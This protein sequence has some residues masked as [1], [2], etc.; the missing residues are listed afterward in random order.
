MRGVFFLV[1]MIS[2]LDAI[3]ADYQLFEQN[4]KVG[5]KDHEGKVVINAAFESLGWSDGSFSVIGQVTGYKLGT[6]WGLIN[7][8]GEQITNPDFLNLIP[9]GGDRIIAR[10]EISAIATKLGCIDLRGNA[11]V[12]FK[13]DG[14]KI[15]GLQAIVFNKVE[16]TFQYGVVNLN[17]TVIIPL[18]FKNIV[19]IGSLRYSVY[20]ENNKA[21]LFSEAG[22]KLT[23]FTIDSIS[24]FRN[25]NAIIYQGLTQ[26]IINREGIIKVAPLYR[27][28]VLGEKPNETRARAFD[29]WLLL[30]NNHKT[31]KSSPTDNLNPY[32]N[33]IIV[34]N[35]NQYGIWDSTLR[36]IIPVSYE[37]IQ[38][39]DNDFAVA[40][41]NG[42]YGLI[43]FKNERVLPFA[44][45]SLL[46]NK[47]FVRVQE[48]LLGKPSWS[49]YDVYG[50]R[51]SERS[52]EQIGEFN[53]KFFPVKNYGL[54]GIMNRYG[55]ETVHC[56]YDS[57]VAFSEDQIVVKF[58][59]HYGIIDFNENWILPPQPFP[60]QL[61]DE[62]H[63]L[64]KEYGI[65]LF[66][67]FDGDLIYFTDNELSVKESLLHEVLPDGTKKEISFQGITVSRTASPITS[68]T[69]IIAEEHEGLRGI[70]RNGKYGFIDK[71]G[72]LRIAN[73]Y[74]AIGNFKDGYAPV[75]I[76]GKW[77]FID[78][79]DNISINPSYQSVS[80]FIKNV[81]IVKR[82]KFGFIDRAGH[83]ILETRYDSI[84][85]LKT[86]NFIVTNNRLYGLANEQG[87]ILIEPRFDS[88]EDL[89]NGF[90]I[91]SRDFKYGLLTRD[92][93]STIPMI[94][95][96]LYYLSS[97]NKYLAKKESPWIS[98][99]L[100]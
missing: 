20:N 3:A 85:P 92:G 93:M 40:K 50:I 75:K 9:T 41:Q 47:K 46:I 56:V 59:G 21:A 34:Q 73:R 44:Y 24:V 18:E 7:I 35:G 29:E 19:P 89:G 68:D 54:S 6:S 36:E 1:F 100:N 55:K 94:Y 79:Q 70:K 66:K 78:T 83:T 97:N 42:K 82:V 15:I 76:L 45:D 28:I 98:L 65:N 67:N 80:D 5:M 49:L 11:T 64:Q 39:A 72:R 60:V 52:Y 38:Y 77:G 62:H 96:Q 37:K 86:N 32:S 57:V 12:P 84:Y 51:K 30:E 63:Y 69:E 87:E 91:V 33:N 4:G 61:V 74:E 48:K 17:G 99:N 13:Y 31:L 53:G 90:V 25:N 27:E 22:I 95:N 23:D 14:I 8:K 58:H 2:L 71:E 88:L 26:G 16:H 10:K 81:A 43:T